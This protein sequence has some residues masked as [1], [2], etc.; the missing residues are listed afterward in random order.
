ML[1]AL[2]PSLV[3]TAEV[4][5][6]S[7]KITLKTAQ[8][9]E[10]N[11][12]HDSVNIFF[13]LLLNFFLK[14]C[15]LEQIIATVLFICISSINNK[16]S[17][18]RFQSTTAPTNRGWSACGP[19]GNSGS[20]KVSTVSNSRKSLKHFRV[21]SKKQK[22]HYDRSLAHNETVVPKPLQ[23]VLMWFSDRNIKKA[24]L[25]TIQSDYGSF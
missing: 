24:S 21:S 12:T 18:L 11:M 15:I 25:R 10:K 17:L 2:S 8:E 7:R 23:G 6:S 1:P 9:G 19:R 20:P 14:F 3:L 5:Y 13:K 4:K 22:H 16:R